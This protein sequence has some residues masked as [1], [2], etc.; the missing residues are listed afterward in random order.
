MNTGT[1]DTSN[2]DGARNQAD[3]AHVALGKLTPPLLPRDIVVRHRLMEKISNSEHPVTL[4][5]APAGF[6][7]SLLMAQCHGSLKS[8]GRP[9]AWLSLDERD[10]DFG[11]FVAHFQE[12]IRR[13]S[14]SP[15][16]PIRSAA[17]S[18]SSVLSDIRDEAFAWLDHIAALDSPFCL[19]FDEFESIRSSEVHVFIADLLR[20]LSPG[21][22]VI[23]GSRSMHALPLSSFELE[24]RV[25]RLEASDLA[26]D[27]AETRDFFSQQIDQRLSASAIEATQVKTEG[28]VAALRLV[29]L[30]LPAQDDA[31]AW[32]V[33]ALGRTGGIAQYLAQNVLVNLPARTYRFLTQTSILE[34]L[35]ANLCDAFLE[36][37]ESAQILEELALANLFL[38]LVD[39]RTN[40]YELHPLFRD[41]LQS[42]LKRTQP[43]MIP[44]LHRKAAN[45]LYDSARYSEAMEHAILSQDSALAIDIL[46]SCIRRFIDFAYYETIAK[47]IDALPAAQIADRPRIQRVRAFVMTAIFR[48]PEAEDALDRLE[49]IAAREGKSLDAVVVAQR[50]LLYEWMDRFDLA[51]RTLAPIGDSMQLNDPEVQAIFLNIKIYHSI[52]RYD[53]S[54]MHEYNRSITALFRNTPTNLWARVYTRCFEAVFEMLLGNTRAAFQRFESALD[55]ASGAVKSAP[56]T[57]LADALYGRGE[58][59][60]AGSWAEENL[61]INRYLAPTDIVILS[62][63]TAARVNYLSG[64]LDRTE[65][66]LA[67]LGDIGDMRGVPRIKAAAWLEKSRIALLCGENELATR[68]FSQGADPAN[69]LEHT[70]VRYYPHELDDVVI[71]SARMD[72]VLG[73]AEAAASRLEAAIGEA[74]NTGRRLRRVRLQSLLAQAYSRLRQRRQA[75]ILLESALEQAETGG[76]IHVFTDEPW[77]LPDLLEEL[78]IRGHRIDK[79]YFGKVIAAIRLVSGRADDFVTARSQQD[80]VT[81]RETEILKLI[82]DGMANKEISRILKISDNTVETH[83]RRIYQKLETKNRT[84]AVA[85]ARDKGLLS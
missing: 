11:R 44:L 43:H 24:G 73:D 67:E 77:W 79:D 19:F 58:L 27:L 74:E 16:A 26:F 18:D 35:D 62:Y 40:R 12:A 20:Q 37:R 28:W 70:S 84:Q 65:S 71:A 78:S 81:L 55:M 54:G 30:A 60:Q 42:E 9:V 25:L 13:L 36:S 45:V 57:Y 48:I 80:I 64:N 69:W 49:S 41:F 1:R 32:I 61:P 53:Y 14:L 50:G 38:T 22:R 21:Q 47:W 34:C 31:G 17:A 75:L 7:K 51:E 83:L 15:V 39:L 10:N 72:L 23:I 52:L 6:G 29:A 8:C 85:R 82:A 68:Y 56:M 59:A 63:R 2:V 66:L 5:V 46:D 76:L 4:V 33:D 3:H